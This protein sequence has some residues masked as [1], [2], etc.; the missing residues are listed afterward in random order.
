[1]SQY[2]ENSKKTS[3]LWG[4][5]DDLENDDDYSFTFQDP[6]WGKSYETR[7][8]DVDFRF[9]GGNRDSFLSTEMTEN[10]K[11]SQF[12]LFKKYKYC[13]FVLCNLIYFFSLETNVDLFKYFLSIS[14]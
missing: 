14:L 11:I 6:T 2:A 4:S 13:I 12:G 8:G 10:G 5:S 3:Y 1:M 7:I 9:I